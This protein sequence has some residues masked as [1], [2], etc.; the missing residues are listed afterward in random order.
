MIEHRSVVNRMIDVNR[1]H[2]VVARTR[3]IALTALQH[4][5]SVYDIF[6]TLLAG[7]TIV[8]PN[9]DGTRD[10]AHWL[11]LVNQEKVTVWNSVPAFMEMF[12]NHLEDSGFTFQDVSQSLRLVILAGDF[13]PVTLPERIRRL[14]RNAK[15][16]S[17]GGPTETTIWDIDYPIERIDPTWKSIPYGKPMANAAYYI[18]K[19]TLE[20]CPD[21][22]FGEMYIGGVGLARGYWQDEQRTGDRFITHPQSGER[23]YSSGDI[24]RFLPDGNIEIA[25]RSDFQVKIRGYRVELGE[26]ESM[27][28]QHPSVRDAVVQAAGESATNKRLVAYVVTKNQEANTAGSYGQNAV[29]VS[30]ANTDSASEKPTRSFTDNL[31]G[32]PSKLWN[33]FNLYRQVKPG[34][35]QLQHY[36]DPIARMEF[37]MKRLGVRG[38]DDGRSFVQFDMSQGDANL[39]SLYKRQSYRHYLQKKVTVKQLG[40]FLRCLFHL[41]V[42]EI[43]FPKYRYPSAGSLIQFNRIFMPRQM[44]WRMSKRDAIITTPRATAWSC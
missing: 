27:L 8:V 26:I 5:L 24:G 35:A 20:P 2:G 38:D 33:A 29:N 10:P 13:I 40:D 14:F 42:D 22:V 16:V 41:R 17:S 31:K 30:T 9:A 23:L 25:G 7:G 21:W 37:K 44:E 19:E 4:D 36:F 32:A 43:P 3:I 28:R 12:V 6:G 15:V 18:L 34:V 11:D 1:R 39:R